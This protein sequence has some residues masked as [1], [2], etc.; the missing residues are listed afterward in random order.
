MPT[1]LATAICSECGADVRFAVGTSQVR[2][3]HCRG[4]LVI[5]EQLLVRL[6][7]PNC[8]GNFCSLD[9]AL[10]GHCPY[11]ETPVLGLTRDNVIQLIAPAK[12]SAPEPTAKLVFLPFW[13]MTGLVY[14]WTIGAKLEVPIDAG[15]GM[16]SGEATALP[17][18]LISNEEAP[19]GRVFDI[20]LADPA[21]LAHGVTSLRFRAQLQTFEPY[22]ASVHHSSAEV[23]APARSIAEA[24]DDLTQQALN[25]GHSANNLARIDCQ[26]ADVVSATLMQLLYPF[27]ICGD[28]IYDAVNGHREQTVELSAP[29]PSLASQLFDDLRIIELRC[30]GCQQALAVESR[31]AVLICDS[32]GRAWQ[33]GEEGLEPITVRYAK[34]QLAS[35]AATIQLPFWRVQCSVSFSG[36]T[37]DKSIDLYQRLGALRPPH[38]E[39]SDGPLHYYTPAFGA[40]RAPRLDPA[41]RALT[42]RQIVPHPLAGLPQHS[43]Q[44]QRFQCFFG[45]SDAARMGYAIWLSIL[46][47]AAWRR[48]RTLRVQT[49]AP[50]LWYLPFCGDGNRE[51]RCLLTGQQFDRQVFRGLAH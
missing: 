28:Q 32:C 19:S 41:A 47:T 46:P 44:R 15:T 20:S 43:T 23:V 31:P 48:A 12:A 38:T 5:C 40:L 9:G 10:C 45:A 16:S 21:T 8:G 4:G 26:R 25:L 1:E 17:S 2:C 3:D 35:E 36:Q 14:G 18:A 33:V 49:S 24:K 29:P 42:L 34:P 27:W 30:P 11:C 51:L 39:V 22:D 50:Q 7:C 13:R 6:S 37:A